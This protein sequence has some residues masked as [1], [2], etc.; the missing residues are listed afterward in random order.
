MCLC[1]LAPALATTAHVMR[2]A[3]TSSHPGQILAIPISVISANFHTEYAKMMKKRGTSAQH[4]RD[5]AAVQAS[6]VQ[7]STDKDTINR[8]IVT[9]AATLLHSNSRLMIG[10][11]KHVEL[12]TRG[13]LVQELMR[14]VDR[15]LRG[16]CPLP[17]EA[18]LPK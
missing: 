2:C 12:S 15:T 16:F 17:N 10:N 3:H 8:T 11:M 1:T 7:A 18:P 4:K 6:A 13:D 9:S 14:D 5:L